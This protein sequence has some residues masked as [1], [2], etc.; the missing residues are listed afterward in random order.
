MAGGIEKHLG[1]VHIA[2]LPAIA[3]FRQSP[4][5]RA[6]MPDTK[7]SITATEEPQNLERTPNDLCLF[8]GGEQGAVTEQDVIFP[9]C[10]PPARI[11]S[12]T[13]EGRSIRCMR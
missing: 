4:R 13:C 12:C 3:Q 10:D 5:L 2:A 7:D 6:E 11:R 1:T 9:V 8:H